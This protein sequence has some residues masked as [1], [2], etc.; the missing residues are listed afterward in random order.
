[1]A[2]ALGIDGDRLAIAG[3]SAGAGLAAR[4]CQ[5]L[6]GSELSL[7]AQLLLCPVLDLRFGSAS[8]QAFATGYLLDAATVR[9]DVEALG[10]AGMVE[11]PRV[12]PLLEPDLAGLPPAQ[13]HVAECDMFRDDGAA[14]AERLTQAGV[15]ASLTCHQGMIHFFYGLGRMVPQ[16]RPS[17]SA[18]GSEFGALLRGLEPKTT[19]TARPRQLRRAS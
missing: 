18:I 19:N 10:V 6:R 15:P 8:H 12:S 11:S 17:L 13:I 14:Y 16:A 7:A 3:E 9:H 4:V 1:M 2:P 5:E